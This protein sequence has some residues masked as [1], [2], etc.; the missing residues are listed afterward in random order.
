MPKPWIQ[1]LAFL[2]GLLLGALLLSTLTG[3]LPYW[4][5]LALAVY[6]ARMLTN[7]YRFSKWL[8]KSLATAPP[9]AWG[10]WEDIFL[11][12]Y[13]AG[14]RRKTRQRRLISLIN[15]FEEA[16]QALPDAVVILDQQGN[17]EWANNNAMTY[18][19][20]NGAKDRGQRLL[21]LVRHPSLADYL[22]KADYTRKALHPS[23]VNEAIFLS[24]QVVPYGDDQFLL[25]SRNITQLHKLE[26]MRQDFVANVSHEM[27]TPLTVINGYLEA[28]A[29]NAPAN[30][31]DIEHIAAQMGQQSMRLQRLVDDL[32][33]L[34]KLDASESLAKPTAIDVPQMVRQIVGD[35]KIMSGEKNHQITSN[36]EDHCLLLGDENEIRSAFSNLISNAV[37]YT[38]E[39]GSIN[40]DWYCNASGAHFL[41]QDSGIGIPSHYI[42]RLTERFYRVD[43]AR[44]RHTG[45]TGLG[46]AIVK[47][48]L[49]RH[50]G[51]LKI[52]SE[53]GKGSSFHCHFPKT[54]VAQKSA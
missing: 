2:A 49:Q 53:P 14:Q 51:A 40:I 6:L 35:S 24:T 1:E 23:P 13:R 34:A 47:H 21:N 32:L 30:V 12:L 45:G 42:P 7:L 10:I 8:K 3:G 18:L 9:D 29:D 31:K 33:L 20:V 11:S 28:M 16:T 46:L 19:G 36:I 54:R 43:V 17:I 44:S 37:R 38:P 5:L 26:K 22:G 27:R 15:R 50:E 48:V 39:S 4:L 41:V 52:D 25:V